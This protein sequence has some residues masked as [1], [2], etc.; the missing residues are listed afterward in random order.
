MGFIGKLL[1]PIYSGMGTRMFY[2]QKYPEAARFLERA[3]KYNP[4]EDNIE[5]TYSRLGQSY[6]RVGSNKKAFDAL[7]KAY[8]LFHKSQNYKE[9]NVDRERFKDLLI[10][11]LNLLFELNKLEKARD[12]QDELDNMTQQ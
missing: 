5:Y 9:D 11:Y 7:N 1:S 12:I 2:Q 10:A 4:K 8:D 3:I 6:L